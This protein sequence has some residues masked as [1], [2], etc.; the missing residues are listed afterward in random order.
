ML[1]EAEKIKRAIE[2]IADAEIEKETASCF[3]VF[4]AKITEAPIGATC[5]VKLIGDDTEIPLAYSKKLSTVSV[6]TLVLV[7]APY[8]TNSSLSN[9]IVWETTDF[10]DING[11]TSYSYVGI[12]ATSSNGILNIPIDTAKYRILQITLANLDINAGAI[13]ANDI[14]IYGADSYLYK[15]GSSGSLANISAATSPANT[16]NIDFGSSSVWSNNNNMNITV[17]YAVK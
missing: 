14:Y 7:A 2:R 16:C 12:G 10:K 4:K 9:A 15:Y 1:A 13:G 11:N 8:S 6:G 5:K 17:L 3:R